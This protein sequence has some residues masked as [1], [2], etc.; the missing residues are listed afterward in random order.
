MT[1]IKK[2]KGQVLSGAVW[3]ALGSGAFAATNFVFLT[4]V[5][6]VLGVEAAG[7]FSLAF[8]TAQILYTV[9]L[10]GMN[11]YQMTD[12]K[13]EY[14]FSEYFFAKIITTGC[15]FLGYIFY[16]LSNIEDN[17]K[18]MITF[19]LTIYMALFSYAEVYQAQLFLHGSLDIS[20]KSLFFR[21]V[22]SMGIFTTVLIILKNIYLALLIAISVN[23]IL[24]RCLA[25]NPLKQYEK[26]N[27]KVEKKR[28]FFLLRTCFVLFIVNFLFT[29]LNNISK[30]MIDIFWDDEIQG[31]YSIIFMPIMAIVL[32]CGFIYKPLLPKIVLYI[33]QQE[34]TGI[35]KLMRGME[36][37]I[38]A[39]MTVGILVMKPFGIPLMNLVFGIELI[40]YLGA[41]ELMVVGAAVVAIANFYYYI[42]VTLRLEKD[43]LI[44][45]IF[46]TISAIISSYFWVMK[47]PIIG[48]YLAFIV[49]YGI[50]D[51]YLLIKIKIYIGKWRKTDDSCS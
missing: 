5:T 23:A 1:E 28:V 14:R 36:I 26:V 43:I 51:V 25:E 18:M 45:A 44:G 13:R 49:G 2:N 31:V 46:G 42:A 11:S 22:L 27:T 4:V 29:F 12:Y 30:Y 32:L 24:I 41:L 10:F 21:S 3:N 37:I 17:Q 9:G 47:E 50:I 20:G 34:K 39:V 7:K 33:K 6:R 40:S 48:G 16:A 35:H 15:M 8:A 19:L 38:I